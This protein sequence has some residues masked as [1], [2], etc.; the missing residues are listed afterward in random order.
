MA[1]YRL[2]GRVSAEADMLANEALAAVK[3]KDN[4]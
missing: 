4:E 1:D 2:D 3:G